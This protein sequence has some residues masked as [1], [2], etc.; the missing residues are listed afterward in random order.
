VSTILAHPRRG[1]DLLEIGGAEIE[2]PTII[3]MLGLKPDGRR[4]PRQGLWVVPPVFQIA[5]DGAAFQEALG[6][7]DEP[8]W[9]LDAVVFQESNRLRRRQVPPLLVRGPQLIAAIS[10]Q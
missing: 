1:R 8:V 6:R 3:A 10:S 2:V 7:A 9:G 5:I 4:L